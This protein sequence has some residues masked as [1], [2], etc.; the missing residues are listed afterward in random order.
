MTVPNDIRVARGTTAY[1]LLNQL[2]ELYP[3]MQIYFDVNGVFNYG[4]IPYDDSNQMSIVANDDLWKDVLIDYSISN[5]FQNVKII[6]MFMEQ[7]TMLALIMLT[8]LQKLL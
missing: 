1:E 5:D 3:H 2:V 6:F 4:Y 7:L 8:G